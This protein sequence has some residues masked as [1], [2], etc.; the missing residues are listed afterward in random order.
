MREVAEG[1]VYGACRDRVTVMVRDLASEET[2]RR[3]PATPDWTVHDAV[4]HLVGTAVDITTGNLDG[5]GSDAW[6]AAQ[7]DARRSVSIPSLLDEW[8]VAAPQVEATITS[9]GGVMAAMAVADVWNHE[10]DIRGALGVEGGRDPEAEHLS[11]LGYAA[12]RSGMVSGA[13]LAALR[14]HSGVDEWQVGEGEPGATVTAEP[15]ELARLICVRRTAEQ[16]RAYRWEGDP[17]PYVALLS[18]DAPEPLRT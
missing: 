13:G 15:Y 14:L 4:A 8:A 3:V 7:V 16:V 17:E 9:I 5:V 1:T 6:T 10:Q 12:L 11:I 18:A 2:E